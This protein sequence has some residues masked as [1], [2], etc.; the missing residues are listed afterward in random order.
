MRR[1]QKE[2]QKCMGDRRL[3]EVRGTGGTDECQGYRG[4]RGTGGT[5]VCRGSKVSPNPKSKC[6]QS[7]TILAILS[8]KNGNCHHFPRNCHHFYSRHK[9]L[10]D[11]H[12]M[13]M[14]T[15][16]KIVVTD[17]EVLVTLGDD[18]KKSGD[19]P[20]PDSCWESKGYMPFSRVIAKTVR[21]I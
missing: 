19:T 10:N 9:I 16:P 7:V 14:V 13:P 11:I 3:S 8:P 20:F 2:T 1:L 4:T 21:E 18:L 6:H 5:H 15:I 17:R 12:K